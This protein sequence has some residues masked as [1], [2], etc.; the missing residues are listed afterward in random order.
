MAE[1]GDKEGKKPHKNK[2]TSQKY[3][4]Y[5]IT[6]NTVIDALFTVTKKIDHG[7]ISIEGLPD[8]VMNGKKNPIVLITGHRR[9]NF[10]EGF[11]SICRSIGILADRFKETQ[12]VYPVHLNP[13]VQ[14]PV[15]AVLSGRKNV[16]LIKPLS[17]V[18]FV[19]LMQRSTIILTDSGGV[20]EEAPSLGKPVLVMRNTTE[21]PEAVEAGTVKL[22]GTDRSIIVRE[23]TRL[24]ENTGYYN[25][26]AKAHNPYGDGHA[27][28]RILHHLIIN[29]Q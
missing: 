5:H 26:M 4:H 27:V 19:A 6:G 13:N 7:V 25:E 8:H 28:D 2:P 15:Y 9:E 11:L 17:Y 12:F 21:S 24:M 1:K 29:L 16:H 20:Q 22:V 23:I 3:K 18:P 14:T 10:G